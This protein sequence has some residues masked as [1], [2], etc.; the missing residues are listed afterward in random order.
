MDNENRFLTDKAS[1]YLLESGIIVN[2]FKEKVV[3]IPKDVLEIKE[4]NMLLSKGEKYTVLVLLGHL[5]E[6]SKEAKELSASSDF[7][8]NNIA[9]AIVTEYVG[10]RVVANF[11]FKF[12][13]P[14]SNNKMFNSKKNAVQWLRDELKKAHI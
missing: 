14:K 5:T 8:K 2:E 11:Y 6:F 1:I 12:N 4:I 13:K 9:N 10:H 7:V 3:V